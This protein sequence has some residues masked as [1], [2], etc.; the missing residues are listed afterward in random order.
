MIPD[1]LDG[2]DLEKLRDFVHED[3]G[4]GWTIWHPEKFTKMGFKADDLP[5]AK[6]V[7]S[8]GKWGITQQGKDVEE[9]TGVW[10]LAFMQLL[11]W[12]LDVDYPAFMGRGFQAR[13][14]RD[15]VLPVIDKLR[16]EKI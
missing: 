15:A 1:F 14:I 7:S 16:E 13:A 10:N 5:V 2:I 4:D 12:R 3:G 11:A 9:L 6:H 8:E